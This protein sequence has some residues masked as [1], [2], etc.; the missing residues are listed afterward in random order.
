MTE[1]W[2]SKQYW[3]ELMMLI[4]F[5]KQVKIFVASRQKR[6]ISSNGRNKRHYQ[7]WWSWGNKNDIIMWKGTRG[8]DWQKQ[9]F[10][11]VLWKRCSENMQQIHRSPMQK[12]DLLCNFIEIVLRHGCS[13]ASLFYIFRT[14]FPKKSSRRLLLDW[15]ESGHVKKFRKKVFL[16]NFVKSTENNCT[17]VL[18]S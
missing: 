1:S 15:L 13:P 17:G 6:K 5:K 12:C 7:Q 8:N 2:T 16:K 10:R 4:L 11:S 18:L 3:S 14:A 9:P